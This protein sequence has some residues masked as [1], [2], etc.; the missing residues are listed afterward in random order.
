L[1]HLAAKKARRAFG[2]IGAMTSA[3]VRLFY[4]FLLALAAWGG[5][6]QLALKDAPG[7]ST[8]TEVR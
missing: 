2:I 8:W 1:L 7:R 6:V 3:Y 5:F 4:A